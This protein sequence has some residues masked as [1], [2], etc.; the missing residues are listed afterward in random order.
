MKA[1]KSG[2]SIVKA[3]DTAC[4]TKERGEERECIALRS[5]LDD[6]LRTHRTMKKSGRSEPGGGRT[7]R[8]RS[9]LDDRGGHSPGGIEANL[10]FA[11]RPTRAYISAANFKKPLQSRSMPRLRPAIS[12][13]MIGAKPLV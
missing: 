6:A 4:L 1:P 8:P 9:Y 11:H 12:V 2:Q 7:D 10:S 3:A 13:P 5:G